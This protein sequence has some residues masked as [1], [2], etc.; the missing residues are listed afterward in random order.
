MKKTIGSVIAV[1]V[2]STAAATAPEWQK[3]ALDRISVCCMAN[4]GTYYPN[5]GYLL[6]QTGNYVGMLSRG[7]GTV[8]LNEIEIDFSKGKPQKAFCK[9]SFKGNDEPDLTLE[10]DGDQLV[11][12]SRRYVSG[13]DYAIAKTDNGYMLYEKT[14]SGYDKPMP[15][16]MKDGKPS[17]IRIH[18]NDKKDKV[19]SDLSFAYPDERSAVITKTVYDNGNLKK[20]V[21]T[22]ETTIRIVDYN[23]IEKNITGGSGFTYTYNDKGLLQTEIKRHRAYDITQ[24]YEYIDGEIFSD[25][26][27]TVWKDRDN[28]ETLVIVNFDRPEPLEDAPD[29]ENKKGNYYFDKSDRLVKEI[30]DGMVR[31]R[32]DN[33]V[34]SAW[35]KMNYVY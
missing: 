18:R 17:K 31:V 9:T 22:E 15:V 10:W 2:F 21:S 32:D 14:N 30:R 25:R 33:D 35:E 29:W 11:K 1:L 5:H 6:M 7:M 16:E 19:H 20:I 3:E 12:V 34:W 28:K 4:A 13:F 23:T 27:Q 24:S 8:R 26:K